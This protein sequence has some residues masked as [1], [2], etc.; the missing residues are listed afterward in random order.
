[1]EDQLKQTTAALT[2]ARKAL[3][4]AS[5]HTKFDDAVEKN[6]S[7]LSSMVHGVMSNDSKTQF[8]ATTSFR[9]HLSIEKNPLQEV[10]NSGVVPRFV[11]FLQQDDQPKL[12]FEAAWALTNIAA[13]TSDQTRIVIENGAVPVL[14][15][16]LS[17]VDKDVCEQSMWALG[18]I[19]GD[20]P[21][22]RNLVLQAQAL[23][24]LLGQLHNNSKLSMLRNGTW[25]LSRLCSGKPSPP[26][27]WVSPALATLKQLICHLDQEVLTD[28]CWALSYLSSGPNEKIAAVIESGVTMRVV[29]LLL[30][31]SPTVQIPALRTIGNMVTGDDLQT[32]VVLNSGALPYLLSLMSSVKKTIKKEA[33]WTISNITAGNKA[34]IQ[35]VIDANIIPRVIH[36]LSHAEFDIKKEAAWA[37][38]NATSGGTPEQIEYLVS[39]G[40]IPP[41][42]ALLTV[43]DNK[44]VTVVLE[45]LANILKVG[46]ASMRDKGLPENPMAQHVKNGGG[47]NKIDQLQRHEDGAIY[48]KALNMLERFF[49]AVVEEP[50][51]FVGCVPDDKCS[52]C[53]EPLACLGVPTLPCIKLGCGH[54]FHQ[55][56]ARA[57]HAKSRTCALCR[58]PV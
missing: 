56:C 12:Q 17:S 31:P 44:I 47:L 1:M 20:S 27:K 42:C 19:A 35:Q 4:A 6:L 22:C 3:T 36:L 45:G 14:V 37:I 26:F 25:T 40:C 28:A 23:Q 48:T 52:M 5:L 10:I 49:G 18:N 29:E 38:S 34:Q 9:K 13:G 39:R 54:F 16:L 7:K 21:Q 58:A 2:A 46:E 51:V 33:V 55:Q 41:L 32:Q 11:E 15:K 8:E 57:W 53:L 30:H 43:A 50:S 24:P